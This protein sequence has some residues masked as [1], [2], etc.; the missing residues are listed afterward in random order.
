MQTEFDCDKPLSIPTL[1]LDDVNN[2]LLKLESLVFTLENTLER[3]ELKLENLLNEKNSLNEENVI[4]EEKKL[5]DIINKEENINL[6]NDKKLDRERILQ[7][8]RDI[9]TEKTYD[10]EIVPGR[11]Q[12]YVNNDLA[13]SLKKGAGKQRRAT[14]I[15]E[16]NIINCFLNIVGMEYDTA[17]ELVKKDGYDLYILQEFLYNKLTNEYSKNNRIA[18]LGYSGTTLGVSLDKNGRIDNIL[19]VGGQSLL[20]T[21]LDKKT[22]VYNFD[23][24]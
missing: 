5:E 23:E 4:N 17:L 6:V 12:R 11:N 8:G 24:F 3:I 7:I 21:P 9:G 19:C 20:R 2:R 16:E 1:N 22:T 10:F 18:R 15:E 14:G 13:M